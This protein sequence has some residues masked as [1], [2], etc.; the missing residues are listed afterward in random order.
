MQGTIEATKEVADKAPFERIIGYYSEHRGALEQ[1]AERVLYDLVNLVQTTAT[2]G[3]AR[4]MASAGIVAAEHTIAAAVKDVLTDAMTELAETGSVADTLHLQAVCA[5]SVAFSGPSSLD[6]HRITADRF[7]AQH[8]IDDLDTINAAMRSGSEI[9]KGLPC[10]FIAKQLAALEA[11]AKEVIKADQRA[12]ASTAV[13]EDVPEDERTTGLWLPTPE[14]P[15]RVALL[16]YMGGGAGDGV[17]P[18]TAQ[19]VRAFLK[20]YGLKARWDTS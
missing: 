8:Q 19:T 2:K 14:V 4:L 13:Q 9:G 20:T 10:N 7:A 15:A 18:I 6:Q 16:R 5:M 11:R 17:V 3:I 1:V 12:A